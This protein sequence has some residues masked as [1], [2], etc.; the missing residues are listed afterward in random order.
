MIYGVTM[1]EWFTHQ[2]LGAPGNRLI[3]GP[4][5]PLGPVP[6]P[7]PAPAVVVVPGDGGPPPL[8]PL[9]AI[10]VGPPP[11]PPIPIV[12]PAAFHRQPANTLAVHG[13]RLTD[14]NASYL[15][16]HQHENAMNRHLLPTRREY[17]NGFQEGT[18]LLGDQPSAQT[19]VDDMHHELN[20]RMAIALNGVPAAER[21]ARMY[22]T[23]LTYVRNKTSHTRMGTTPPGL[24]VRVGSKYNSLH[25]FVDDWTAINHARLGPYFPYARDIRLVVVKRKRDDHV[26][27]R[28]VRH[29]IHY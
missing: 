15:G 25:K 26:N 11:I 4:V 6:P 23:L 5:P 12:P 28:R 20:A 18:T 29:R 22:K 8:P 27:D 1:L 10:P 9:P 24:N 13:V 2:V 14:L 17:I 16:E 7:G 3:I 21:P 19:A